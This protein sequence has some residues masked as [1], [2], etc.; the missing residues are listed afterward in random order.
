M[1]E[2]YDNDTEIFKVNHVKGK[3]TYV[4]AWIKKSRDS[5]RSWLKTYNDN[6]EYIIVIIF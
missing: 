2:D 1:K 6:E 4:K 3:I 5:I